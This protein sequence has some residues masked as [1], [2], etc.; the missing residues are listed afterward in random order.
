MFSQF[1]FNSIYLTVTLSTFKYVLGVYFRWSGLFSKYLY[2]L[3]H[4][5]DPII[6]FFLFIF[7]LCVS[8][9]LSARILLYIVMQCSQKTEEGA[10][11]LVL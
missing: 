8:V 10:G 11:A 5:N 4:V 2:L 3:S 1:L 9:F 6:S 7:I